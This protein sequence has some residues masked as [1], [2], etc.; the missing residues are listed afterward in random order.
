MRRR[1][2]GW[3]ASRQ[4]RFVVELYRTGRVDL[5]ARAV[6]MSRMSAY[7]LRRREGAESFA[8]A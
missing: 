7:R 2:D 3:C 1:R 5:A 8:Y 6:G 4:V